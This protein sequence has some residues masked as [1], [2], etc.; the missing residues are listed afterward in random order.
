MSRRSAALIL[1]AVAV[2][3][4]GA[5]ALAAKAPAKLC[6]LIPDSGTDSGWAN[7]P[8]VTTPQVEI[9][10][11][12]VATGPKTLVGVLRLK[13]AT[14]GN[15]D[16]AAHY[17]VQWSLAFRIGSS[18]YQFHRHM[19]ATG[20]VMNDAMTQN[21]SAIATPTVTVDATSITW[22]VPRSVVPELK[23]TKQLL[24][25]IHAATGMLAASTDTASKDG[26]KYPD[27]TP[28]CVKAL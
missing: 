17:Y 6:Q 28:S 18:Q 9:T 4:T 12:D 22:T 3:A 21:N 20:A 15:P 14:F 13:S 10:S 25:D 8:A 11:V 1:A 2:A 26:V 24:T 5:P 7:Q 27:K 16:P 19:D 23:K